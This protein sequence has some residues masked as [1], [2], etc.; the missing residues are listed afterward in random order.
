MMFIAL[1]NRGKHD[2]SHCFNDKDS[3]NRRCCCRVSVTNCVSIFTLQNYNII[4]T[5]F[6][7][8]HYYIENRNVALAKRIYEMK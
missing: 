6:Y 1:L 3:L 8:I 5:I 2:Y 7:L 4:I